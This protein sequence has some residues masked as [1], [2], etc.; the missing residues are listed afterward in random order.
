MQ[1][2]GP[3]WKVLLGRRYGLVAKQT[4]ANSMPPAPF[5]AVANITFK[6]QA[7]GLNL[8]RVPIRLSAEFKLC[9]FF[10]FL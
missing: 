10:P 6:F 2:G 3:T 5:E 4:G 8:T 9:F 7:V 1:G